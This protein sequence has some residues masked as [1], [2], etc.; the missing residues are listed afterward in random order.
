MSS[1]YAA[2]DAASGEVAMARL[3]DR[4]ATLA[5][6]APLELSRMQA[7]SMPRPSPAVQSALTTSAAIAARAAERARRSRSVVGMTVDGFIS[8]CS[9]VPYALVALALRLLMARI[10]FLDGQGRIEGPRLS[11]HVPIEKIPFSLP[12]KLPSLDFSA[13]L[14]VQIRADMIADFATVS[15]PIPLPPAI[16]AYAV[17]YLEFALPICLVLGFAT[18]FASLGLLFITALMA[19]FVVP[20]TLAGEPVFWGAILIVLLSLGGGALSIDNLIRMIAR[21]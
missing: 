10:F 19:I 1:N 15:P 4:L 14:P 21:R 3:A 16:A 9:L 12:F 20:N 7:V 13:L 18:R 2:H 17:G 5:P 11:L 6:P 8:A